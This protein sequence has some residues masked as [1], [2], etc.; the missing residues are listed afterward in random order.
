[1]A[2]DATK[3][4]L[5]ALRQLSEQ[6]KE[7]DRELLDQVL[8]NNFMIEGI[9]GTVGFDENGLCRTHNNPNRRYLI[10]Q[11]KNGQFV[12]LASIQ[13]PNPI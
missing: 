1:M 10:L 13:F 11:V 4:I 9:T 6:K 8:K 2:Y 7:F 3:V 5:T 12:P